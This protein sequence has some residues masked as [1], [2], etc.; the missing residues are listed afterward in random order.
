MKM[1]YEENLHTQKKQS[2]VLHLNDCVFVTFRKVTKTHVALELL[3]FFNT[4]G[5]GR[6]CISAEEEENS[7]VSSF[8]FNC[9]IRPHSEF[10][11]RPE[12][13]TSC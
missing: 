10:G 13:H 4:K 3:F 2:F 5:F 11:C 7:V 12:G 8:S 9:A 1:L 6:L